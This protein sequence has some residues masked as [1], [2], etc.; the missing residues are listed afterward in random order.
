MNQEYTVEVTEFDNLRNEYMQHEAAGVDYIRMLQA[1][2]MSE[3]QGYLDEDPAAAEDYLTEGQSLIQ[4]LTQ[5]AK[6]ERHQADKDFVA[7]TL[8]HLEEEKLSQHFVPQP[9]DQ[10]WVYLAGDQYVCLHYGNATDSVRLVYTR[11]GVLDCITEAVRQLREKREARENELRHTLQM[12]QDALLMAQDNTKELEY[13]R[14][15]RSFHCSMIGYKATFLEETIRQVATGKKNNK[16]KGFDAALNQNYLQ[17]INDLAQVTSPLV[18]AGDN[19]TVLFRFALSIPQKGEINVSWD[20]F[21]CRNYL[22]GHT[23]NVTQDYIPDLRS[24]WATSCMLEMKR[25]K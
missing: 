6:S 4:E 12:M 10:A 25:L 13:K 3:Y 1:Q 8:R 16:G 19:Q 15:L 14:L 20:T 18:M 9:D 24:W 21:N 5:W 23:F 11:T 7:Y 17:F 22:Y 2:L